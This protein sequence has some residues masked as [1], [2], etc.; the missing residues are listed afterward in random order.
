MSEDTIA[1]RSLW[2]DAMRRLRKNRLAVA[3]G[4]CVLLLLLA[5]TIIPWMGN[6]N[7]VFASHKAQQTHAKFQPPS[8]SANAKT[9]LVHPF[10]TDELGR[11]L[12]TRVLYGGRI[13]LLIGFV[14]AFVAIV[15][16]TIYGAIAGYVGGRSD[17]LMMR[18]VDLIYAIPFMF[19]VIL[20]LQ[21]AGRGL[22]SIF[23]A[24]GLF[25]WLT[26]AIVVRGQILTYKNQEFVQAARTIGAGSRRIIFRHLLPNVMGPVIVYATLSVPSII[27]LESFLSFLGLGVQ[28]PHTSWGLLAAEGTRAVNAVD[29]HAWVIV[30]PSLFLGVTLLS[31][32]FLGDG[33]RDALDPK[34]KRT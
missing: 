23:L 7:W 1:G 10:G 21:V 6:N 27:L 28:E 16:G 5:S 22:V 19:L 9:G 29:T 24:L 18:F 8:L 26:P 3:G 34:G 4:I 17:M 2:Q 14:G 25:M 31:L 15:F 11:D 32:N 33:L 30:F 20:I 13:S 12:F